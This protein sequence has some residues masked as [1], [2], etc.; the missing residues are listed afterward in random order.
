MQI[1]GGRHRGDEG[2]GESPTSRSFHIDAG[3]FVLSHTPSSIAHR[4][5]DATVPATQ[6]HQRGKPS[7][8]SPQTVHPL[9][10]SVDTGLLLLDVPVH[11]VGPDRG[12]GKVRHDGNR[13]HHGGHDA[14]LFAF[15]G[16]HW[17]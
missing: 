17:T 7:I 1:G 6:R 8:P 15:D 10:V 5:G 3:A 14:G 9:T 4:S 11:V 16:P 2:R 13:R 12:V